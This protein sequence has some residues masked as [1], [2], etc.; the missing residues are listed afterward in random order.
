VG[1]TIAGG[2]FF[3]RS[4]YE[5]VA[6]H[7]LQKSIL[8]VSNPVNNTEGKP[9][10]DFFDLTILEATGSF[11]FKAPCPF[12]LSAVTTN[13]S[14]SF[15]SFVG[16]SESCGLMFL[17]PDLSGPSV[18]DGG[19]VVVAEL[20][21]SGALKY[22]KLT[23]SLGHFFGDFDLKVQIIE[24]GSDESPAKAYTI[25]YHNSNSSIGLLNSGSICN[26][27]AEPFYLLQPQQE[28]F[29]ICV[30]AGGIGQKDHFSFGAGNIEGW[31]VSAQTKTDSPPIGKLSQFCCGFD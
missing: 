18:G 2:V 6:H 26:S 10:L 20:P 28:W 29:S 11:E 15:E 5:V 22:V 31:T 30:Q 24:A 9:I 27:Y 7:V 21:G 3:K 16:V 19:A 14:D 17:L 25:D 1:T 4:G 23:N 12:N 8:F 13:S